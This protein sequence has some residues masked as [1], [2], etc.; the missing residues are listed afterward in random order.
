MIATADA[1]FLVSLYGRDINTPL[2]EQWMRSAGVPIWL[3]PFG[4]FEAENA[5]RLSVFRGRLSPDEL[6]V[7]LSGM[8]VDESTGILLV[9]DFP[10]STIA[11]AAGMLSGQTTQTQG[12]RAFDVL[13]VAAA[14]LLGADTF[15]SFDGRQ[16]ELADLAG[17]TVAP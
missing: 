13:H 17:L 6:T 15:L 3:T 14:K 9:R 4:W 5:L 12:G 10:A 8:Q 2:A 7:A 1:S 11:G 16:R